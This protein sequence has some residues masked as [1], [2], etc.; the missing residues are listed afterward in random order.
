MTALDGHVHLPID[1]GRVRR[2][3]FAVEVLDAVTLSRVVTGITLTVGGMTTQPLTNAGGLFVWTLPR[4]GGPISVPV[5]VSISVDPGR[6]PYEK[7]SMAVPPIDIA[8]PPLL[9]VPL[10]PRR[11]YPFAPGVAGVR[12]TLTQDATVKPFQP[13]AQV[14]VWLQWVDPAISVTTWV[15]S[16]VRSLTNDDGD[17]AAIARIAVSQSAGLDAQGHLRLRLAAV[18]S[19]ITQYSPEFA[20]PQGRVVNVTDP[21]DPAIPAFGWTTFTP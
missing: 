9:S 13:L 5:P 17:F 1:T 3:H 2:A 8:K 18:Y 4:D 7:A 6:L 16:P 14:P 12:A 10:A 11:D 20:I 15:D 21:M 19:S